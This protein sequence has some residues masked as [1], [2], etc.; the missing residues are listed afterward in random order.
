MRRTLSEI[1]GRRATDGWQLV[2]L[3]RIRHAIPRQWPRDLG[4]HLP[5]SLGPHVFIAG[6][7][8]EDSS[9]NGAL[10]SGRL[11]AAACLRS[12]A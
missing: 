7:H 10:R 2:S 12:F 9:T 5:A 8:L 1:L 4:T 11:A 3:Q 6:D